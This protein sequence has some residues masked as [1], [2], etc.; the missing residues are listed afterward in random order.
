MITSPVVVS[1]PSLPAEIR[2]TNAPVEYGPAGRAWLSPSVLMSFLAGFFGVFTVS[3][4]GEMPIGELVLIAAAGWAVLCMVFNHTWPGPLL[5]S[6][7][8]WSLLTAQFIALGSYIFSDLY[9]HSFPLDM[10]RGWS[11]MVF[12]AIDIIAIAYLFGCAPRN[13]LIFQFGQCLG[14]VASALILGPLFGDMW[15]FGVGYPLT[16]LIFFIAPFAGALATMTAAGAVGMVH[17]LMD[18]RSLGGI[19]LLVGMLTFL[20]IMPRRFRLWLAPL[21]MIA[22]LGAV[23]WVSMQTQGNGVRATRSD[24]ERSAMATAALEAFEQSPL[25]GQGSWF[26]HS[27][28]YD[29][30]MLIRHAAAKQAKV[31]GFADPN[32]D[33]GAVAVHSQILVA[34]AEGGLFGGAFFFVYGGGLLW[35][36]CHLVFV[37]RWHRLTPFCTLLLLSALWDFFCSPFSGAQRISIA[38]VC[39][40]ILLVQTEAISPSLATPSRQ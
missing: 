3:F 9:R 15:K 22:A 10:A 5:R 24:V 27:D 28:V 7:F 1:Q 34:L 26:S 33:P 37:C 14:A 16:F 19:C 29:N 11:R 30:F 4:V 12:L 20:Q 2:E 40:L 8:L 23:R 21:M 38:T 31:G 6:R 25:I 32:K 17:F 39:G 36:L 13:F 18:F 35:T